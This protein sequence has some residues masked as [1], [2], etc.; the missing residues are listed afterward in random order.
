MNNKQEFID[1]LLDIN[2]TLSNDIINLILSFNKCYTEK[3]QNI[4]ISDISDFNSS[5]YNYTDLLL[6]ESHNI[7]N[8]KKYSYC[9]DCT[10]M[11]LDKLDDMINEIN[12]YYI[13][14]NDTYEDDSDTSYE[15]MDNCWNGWD[16]NASVDI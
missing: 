13:C 3:C 9:I 5:Y 14:E 7:N 15:N 2:E 4:A 12:E 6:G 10:D 11:I 1:T 8:I 16:G